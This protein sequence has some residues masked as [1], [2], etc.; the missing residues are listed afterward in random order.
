MIINSYYWLVKFSFSRTTVRSNT[1][2]NETAENFIWLSSTATMRP[3]TIW[4]QSLTAAVCRTCSTSGTLAAVTRLCTWPSSSIARP[5]LV[6][7]SSPARRWTSAV[8]S[9]RRRCWSPAL[10][11][12]LVVSFCWRD[13]SPTAND[14]SWW[15]TALTLDCRC[16]LF[17]F[18]F[19]CPT[20]TYSTSQVFSVVNASV[21]LGTLPVSATHND[22]NPIPAGAAPVAC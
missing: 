2:H 15:S 16:R 21:T 4:S 6:Y 22:E 10:S 11:V 1:R 12:G 8:G 14:I 7:W 5:S 17:L 18:L 13:P 20:P 19:T 3:C 9:V